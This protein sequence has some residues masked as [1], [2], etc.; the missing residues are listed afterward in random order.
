MRPGR[1]LSCGSD[2]AALDA[3]YAPRNPPFPPRASDRQ[4]LLLHGLTVEG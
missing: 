4:T 1:L 3:G 2:C